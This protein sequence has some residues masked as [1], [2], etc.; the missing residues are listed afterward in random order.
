MTHIIKREVELLPETTQA[1]VEGPKV[2]GTSV[3]IVGARVSL[4][5][6]EPF[7]KLKRSKSIGL[8]LC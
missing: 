6:G 4:G 2:H 7:T 5:A 1:K 3:S 8:K